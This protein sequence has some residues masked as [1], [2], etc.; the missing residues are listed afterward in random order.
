MRKLFFL[1]SIFIVSFLYPEQSLS[2]KKPLK[3]EEK[4]NITVRQLSEALWKQE[5]VGEY[6]GNIMAAC[7][8]YGAGWIS[9]SQKVDLIIS[10]K[11][12]LYKEHPE[13]K[14]AEKDIM[15]L[16]KKYKKDCFPEFQ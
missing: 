16:Y 7:N 13:P 10:A 8:A 4:Y 2:E 3:E 1:A 11:A 5:M 14:I 15:D 12:K 6:K 9:N